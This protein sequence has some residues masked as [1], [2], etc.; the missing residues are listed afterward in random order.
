VNVHVFE[1]LEGVSSRNMKERILSDADADLRLFIKMALDPDITF[2][3]TVGDDEECQ[4][5]WSRA[6]SG[7][8]TGRGMA[9][10]AWVP[11]FGRSLERFAA[12]ETTGNAASSL[13]L[14]IVQRAPTSLHAKWAGRIINRNL[15]AG[16]DIRTYNK[17]FEK[18]KIK[19]FEVQLADVYEGQ[20]LEGCWYVQPKLDGNRVIL[21]DGKAYSRNGKLYP[22]CE[23]V[24]GDLQSVYPG[25]FKKWV[26]DGE[27]MGDLGFD[28]SSGALRRINEK[29]RERATFTYWGFDLIA[30]EDWEK[31]HTPP[32]SDRIHN[33]LL[34]L[35]NKQLRHVRWV[36]TSAILSPNLAKINRFLN[37]YLAQGFEG[38]MLK[39]A[40]ARY[41]FKRGPNLLKVKKFQ[42]ADLRIDAFYE[43][44]GRH[45][46]RLGGIIVV[47][48]IDGKP[49][50]SKVGS[51]FDDALRE[52][53]WKDQKGW[54]GATVQVQYQDFTKDGSLR[55][56]VF[57]MRRRDKE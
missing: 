51:G 15:R 8:N 31:R 38:A 34:T 9:E 12:R 30:R 54:W 13:A 39:D 36:P 22:N 10:S 5:E 35:D 28:Q 17:V 21:M 41:C 19:K 56:P 46:G 48:Q 37:E 32:M 53:I 44:K 50:E 25:F 52:H 47:G 20:D 55:F 14:E 40:A 1:E 29:N 42:D 16:F 27:M 11:W 45:K 26:V 3:V 23:H 4:R 7:G 33:A 24:I 2:G 49:V 6:N 43:G 57:I 18:K